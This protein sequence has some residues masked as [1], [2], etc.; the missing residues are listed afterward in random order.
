VTPKVVAI[1]GPTGVGKSAVSIATAEKIDAE[2]VSI[3]SMQTYIGMDVGTDKVTADM[4]ARVPHHLLDVFEPDHELTVAEFQELAR[5]AIANIHDRGKLPLLVGGSGLYFRAV[6]DDLKFPPRSLE[7]RAA[8]EA[9]AERIG[10]EAMYERL[11]ELDPEAA[12]KIEPGNARRIVRA[13]EVIEITG[14]PFSE[15]AQ[16]WE[17]YES[18]YN[19]SVVG[20]QRPRDELF[21]R[22]ETRVNRMLNAGLVQEARAIA[23]RGMSRSARQA[24]G[25]RQVLDAVPGTSLEE[26][27]DEIVRATK[28]FARRQQSWFL[29]DPRVRW[30]DADE[31]RSA[32][33]LARFFI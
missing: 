19:L 21:S 11:N 31:L 25:Y 7:V 30:V 14:R 6:V 23:V 10:V 3:D 22:I 12:G 4:R 8:L 18:I 29:A 20:L 33:E 17:R 24:L 2:I 27:R 13:L 26:I 1:V 16:A 32:E 9:D 15:N 28:R 5:D